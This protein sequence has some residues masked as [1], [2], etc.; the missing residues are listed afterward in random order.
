MPGRSVTCVCFQVLRGR[1]SS[2]PCVTGRNRHVC[3]SSRRQTRK[4]TSYSPTDPA[5]EPCH[6]PRTFVRVLC[7]VCSPPT[8]RRCVHSTIA[9]LSFRSRSS[10][11]PTH[12]SHRALHVFFVCFCR[13][14]F[15][16][17]CARTLQERIVLLSG[18]A[19]GVGARLCRGATARSRKD[20]PNAGN[21]SSKRLQVWKNRMST[22]GRW[23]ENKS[24]CAHYEKTCKF[25]APVFR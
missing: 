2:R 23:P 12:Q 8:E 15:F 11:P 22:N 5:G 6:S 13:V 17:L 10:P 24:F 19:A 9:S 18:G 7:V 3:L 20:C 14:F 1:C 4:A 25:A 21:P 16:F